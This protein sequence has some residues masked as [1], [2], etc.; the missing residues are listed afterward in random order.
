MATVTPATIL[1]RFNTRMRDSEDTTFTSGE[2]DEFYAAALDDPYCT[3]LTRD[4]SLTIVANQP[5]YTIPTGFVGNL[6]DVGYNVNDYG[7]TRYLDR[8]AFDCIDGTLIF[9]Y[10]YSSLP[11][12]KTLYLV[13]EKQLA[14]SDSAP[15]Y[16]VPYIIELMTIEAFEFLK[17]NLTTRFLR[18]DITM[19]EIIAA[20]STHERRAEKLRATLANRRSVRG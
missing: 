18:N 11:A 14:T 3:K 13:G 20:I 4:T 16:L 7:Y 10:G 12:G 8:E 19:S 9:S 5:T 2:K 15:D 1:S 6:T 17:S